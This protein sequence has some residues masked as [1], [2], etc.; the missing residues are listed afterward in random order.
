MSD[1]FDSELEKLELNIGAAFSAPKR[2]VDKSK[3]SKKLR[4]LKSMDEPKEPG[5]EADE[6]S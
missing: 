5:M 4:N 1:N 3:N 6:D 2:V